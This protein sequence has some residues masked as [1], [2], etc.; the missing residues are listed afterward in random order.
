[1][2]DTQSPEFELEV[3]ME[4]VVQNE[5]PRSGPD[6]EGSIR[7]ANSA[8]DEEDDNLIYERESFKRDRAQH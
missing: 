1:M 6:S 5:A 4:G 3:E 2:Q 8:T 7:E